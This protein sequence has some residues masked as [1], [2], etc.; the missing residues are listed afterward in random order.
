MSRRA[1]VVRMA[2]LWHNL[3]GSTAADLEADWQVTISVLP[4]LCW[5]DRFQ[6]LEPLAPDR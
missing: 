4:S 5:R 6:L 2:H 3:F 1:P